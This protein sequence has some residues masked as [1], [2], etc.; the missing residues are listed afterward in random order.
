MTDL[1]EIEV[2]KAVRDRYAR[3]AISN[4]S[5]CCISESNCCGANSNV[6]DI[7][8][9]AS[10][11]NA[12]CGSPPTHI[13]PKIGDTMLD[14]GSDGGIDVFRASQLVG[15]NGLAIG[16]DATSEMISRARETAKKYGDEYSNVEF[17]LG[18]IENLPVSE[19]R[20]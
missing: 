19:D 2:R 3:L 1:S 4:N 7:P 18:E 11:V 15:V 17:R 16:V 20:H 12:G 8:L 5:S 10:S 13:S 14:L 6:E 9:E